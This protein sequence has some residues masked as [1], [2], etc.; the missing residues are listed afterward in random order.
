MVDID[1]R[2]SKP[3]EQYPSSVTIL[4]KVYSV[5]YTAS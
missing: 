1:L 3:E 2:M 5:I 4:V